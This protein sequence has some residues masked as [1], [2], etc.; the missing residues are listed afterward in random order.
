MSLWGGGT[1]ARLDPLRVGHSLQG[2]HQIL[3][4]KDPGDHT[5]LHF[6]E[7]SIFKL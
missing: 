4:G 1:F 2:L 5:N 6:G 7:D 3:L